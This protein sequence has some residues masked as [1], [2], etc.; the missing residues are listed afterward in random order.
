MA[1]NTSKG[2]TYPTSGDSITPL[3]SVFALMASTTNTAL[4]AINAGTDITAGTLPVARGGTGGT[5]QATAAAAL[6]VVP[7]SSYYA[8]GKNA[9][10]NGA[11]DVWQRTTTSNSTTSTG[12]WA[13]RWRYTATG[14]SAKVLSQSRESFTAGSAPVAGYESRSFLRVAVTSGGTGFT[15]EAVEQPIEDVRT[16]AGSTVTLS[17]WAKTTSSSVNFTPRLTQYFGTGGSADVVTAGSSITV[18][19]SWTRFTQTFTVPSVSG[20][21]IVNTN[22]ALILSIVPNTLNSVYTLD[23]WGVQLEQGSIATAF[24]T[25]SDTVAGEVALCQRYYYR[26]ANSPTSTCTI[27][28]GVRFS[29]TVAWAFVPFPV[30]MRTAPT[31]LETAGTVNVVTT[32]GLDAS[33]TTFG[34]ASTNGAR[35]AC[36]TAAVAAAGVGVVVRLTGTA[37]TSY[38]GFSAEI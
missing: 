8:A 30:T 27:A 11:F 31:A 5:T 22:S 4:G 7:I 13:D 19:T 20:K 25:A 2:I 26:V 38:L 17:F 10:I 9:V 37:S 14:G 23:L 36:T 21:T 32:S 29:T 15:F 18:T 24:S 16:Y 35:I 1:A 12:Y 3:E 28:S 33:S 6:G 34:E